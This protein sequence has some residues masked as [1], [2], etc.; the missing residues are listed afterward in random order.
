MLS[1]PV[2]KSLPDVIDANTKATAWVKENL[3]SVLPNAARMEAG[4]IVAYK[5]A[6]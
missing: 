2:F 4:E 3:S 1:V 5:G 6:E